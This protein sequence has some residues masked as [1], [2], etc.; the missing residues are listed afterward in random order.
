MIAQ[1]K[2]LGGVASCQDPNLASW[3]G[4]EAVDNGAYQ[5]RLCRKGRVVCSVK[6][7]TGVVRRIEEVVFRL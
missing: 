3:E 7:V 5:G 4:R 6:H 1:K 2:G